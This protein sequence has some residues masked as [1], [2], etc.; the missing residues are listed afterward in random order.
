MWTGYLR[1]A[2]TDLLRVIKKERKREMR[3]AKKKKEIFLSSRCHICS[4]LHI[5]T[6]QDVNSWH[7]YF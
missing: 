7:S 1:M 6:E 4:A 3:M 2:D 5:H